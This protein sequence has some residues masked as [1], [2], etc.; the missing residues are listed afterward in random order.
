MTPNQSISDS[1]TPLEIV[2]ACLKM[3]EAT[4]LGMQLVRRY[5]SKGFGVEEL[6]LLIQE[7]ECQIAEIKRRIIN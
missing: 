1:S 7:A 4:L 5:L 6:D 3:M 2:L